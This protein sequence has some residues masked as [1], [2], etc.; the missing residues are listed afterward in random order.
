MSY[1]RWSSGQFNC[2]VYCYE[3]DRG[4][5]VRVATRRTAGIPSYAENTNPIEKALKLAEWL[6]TAEYKPIGLPYDGED[7][8]FDDPA[9]CAE[10]LVHLKET[11]Y[12][13]PQYAID[14]LMEE[15]YV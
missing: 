13:V 11:G 12:N 1:C 6:K 5:C 15:V 14:A 3:S 10:W 9:S 2:D 7:F 4:Y 8:Y